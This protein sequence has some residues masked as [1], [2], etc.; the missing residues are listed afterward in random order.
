MRTKT[1]R[2]A[3]QHSNRR[4][5]DYT[6]MSLKKRGL[7]LEHMFQ[8]PWHGKTALDSLMKEVQRLA[9]K[10]EMWMKEGDPRG[11]R[12]REGHSL[13]LACLEH[14][15]RRRRMRFQARLVFALIPGC[16]VHMPNHAWSCARGMLTPGSAPSS[17]SREVRQRPAH[18]LVSA[19]AYLRLMVSCSDGD[20][21]CEQQP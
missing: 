18:G 3:G 7:T 13:H 21:P 16:L 5:A 8:C 6:K 20:A 17:A 12:V 4:L 14:F 10:L 15:R 2:C 9:R 1:D 11:L 19:L